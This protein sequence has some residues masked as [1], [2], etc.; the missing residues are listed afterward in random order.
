LSSEWKARFQSKSHLFLYKCDSTIKIGD[1]MPI[2]DSLETRLLWVTADNV[3][4]FLSVDNLSYKFRL[5]SKDEVE[6]YGRSLQSS[7]ENDNADNDTSDDCGCKVQITSSGFISMCC[8]HCGKK[9]FLT[10]GKS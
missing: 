9:S 1:E 2:Y 6:E 8:P 7:D 3:Y 10:I 4:T 5:V